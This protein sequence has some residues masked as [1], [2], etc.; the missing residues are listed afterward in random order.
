MYVCAPGQNRWRKNQLSIKAKVGTIAY[1]K[2]W[3]KNIRVL[4]LN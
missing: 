3:L 4:R 1:L 2:Y